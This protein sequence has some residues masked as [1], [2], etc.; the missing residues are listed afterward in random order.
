M[1][2]L[3][4]IPNEILNQIAQTKETGIDYVVVS[5]KLKDARSFDQVAI[6]AGCVIEV[7]GFKKI[8]FR[9]EDTASMQVTHETWNFREASDARCKS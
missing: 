6:S 8:P 2:N 1:K 3:I 7:R 5:V 4:P 9:G